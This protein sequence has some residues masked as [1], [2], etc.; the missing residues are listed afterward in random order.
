MICQNPAQPNLLKDP[1]KWSSTI[2]INLLW[3]LL[4]IQTFFFCHLKQNWGSKS[5]TLT[6]MKCLLAPVTVSCKSWRKT[7]NSNE[8]TLFPQSLTLPCSFIGP[9]TL[10]IVWKI[11]FLFSV[12]YQKGFTWR[13][14]L[15]QPFALS[16]SNFG[17]E[18]LNVPLVLLILQ[19]QVQMSLVACQFTRCFYSTRP[20]PAFGR[21]A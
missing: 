19:L 3:F 6:Q 2:E 10:K 8:L 9:A 7:K 1:L 14:S 18:R 12:N 20:W 4:W 17:R 21:R 15:L 11:V 5:D 16:R 13:K